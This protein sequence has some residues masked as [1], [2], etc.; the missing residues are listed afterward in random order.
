MSDPFSYLSNISEDLVRLAISGEAHFGDGPPTWKHQPTSKS[1]IAERDTRA[2]LLHRHGAESLM[3]I[4]NA[5]V[6][7]NRCG[8]GAC[9]ECGRAMQRFF[10][11]EMRPL[12]RPT[13]DFVAVS[14][15][16]SASF[17]IGELH[18]LDIRNFRADFAERLHKSR[19]DFAVGGIDFTLNE[20]RKGRFPAHWAPHFWFLA[21]RYNRARWE[22]LLRR[23][24]VRTPT[25]P[26]PIKIQLWD[27]RRAALGYALK[28]Q[29]GRR[30][31]RLGYRQ[32]GDGTRR[33]KITCYDRLRS[34]ERFELYTFLAQIGLGSRILMIGIDT[35]HWPVLRLSE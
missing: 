6:P 25:V 9:P 31:S 18:K 11:R 4:L 2:R 10:V 24:F 8:S 22:V 15:V 19:I 20:H 13:E 16:P 28:T 26:R 1:A 32:Y 33:C 29:F 21:N 35:Q 12:L 7:N 17:E 5:C 14:V 23:T 27:G 30:I 3:E 34:A